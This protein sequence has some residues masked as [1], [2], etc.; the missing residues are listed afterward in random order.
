MGKSI[1]LKLYPE[2]SEIDRELYEIWLVIKEL[3]RE[4]S[5]TP[6]RCLYELL[7]EN[8]IIKEVRNAKANEK[9]R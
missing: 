3:A 7:S 1:H 6:K 9:G 5:I 4:Q 8:R 2:K